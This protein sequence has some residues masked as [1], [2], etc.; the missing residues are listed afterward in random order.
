MHVVCR[1]FINYLPITTHIAVTG[2]I[3]YR[4]ESWNY[5]YPLFFLQHVYSVCYLVETAGCV[6][7]LRLSSAVV[8]LLSSSI[9]YHCSTQKSHLLVRCAPGTVPCSA[10]L[11]FLYN[12]LIVIYPYSYHWHTEYA[13]ALPACAAAEASLC[14]RRR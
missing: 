9:S 13:Q 3:P 14:R 7:M 8:P 1:H 4:Q 5:Y 11:P 10:V 2:G 12:I 6:G